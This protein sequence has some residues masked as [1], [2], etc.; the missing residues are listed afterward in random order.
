LTL[1]TLLGLWI[2]GMVATEPDNAFALASPLRHFDHFNRG[3]LDGSDVV[4]FLVFAAFFL[5]LAIRR[6][7]AERLG[8]R[9]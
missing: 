1:G 9:P 8:G 2:T 7:D 5:L 3:L 6:L 4:Y